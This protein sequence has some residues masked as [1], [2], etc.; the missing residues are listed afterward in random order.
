MDDRNIEEVKR[1]HE[2]TNYDDDVVK[3]FPLLNSSNRSTSTSH[4]HEKG[5][6]RFDG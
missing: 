2:V 1:Y 4:E 6:K 3:F 5:K